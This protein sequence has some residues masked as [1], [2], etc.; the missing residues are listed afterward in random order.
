MNSNLETA[1]VTSN[2]GNEE[3]TARLLGLT[4]AAFMAMVEF[5]FTSP[6]F[7]TALDDSISDKE[8]QEIYK[9]NKDVAR[10]FKYLG[11]TVRLD[12][13]KSRLSDIAKKHPGLSTK[14]KDFI[15]TIAAAYA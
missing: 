9:F 2:R 3:E 13:I 7:Q 11:K 14:Q 10:V 4:L 6:Q 15:T 12:F 5:G 8:M 1:K